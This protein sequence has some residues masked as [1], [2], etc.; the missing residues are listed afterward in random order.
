MRKF[1]QSFTSTHKNGTT[2]TALSL[3]TIMRRIELFISV[4]IPMWLSL[5]EPK[6]NMMGLLLLLMCCL[7]HI[8]LIK[9]ILM[10]MDRPCLLIMCSCPLGIKFNTWRCLNSSTNIMSKIWSYLALISILWSSYILYVFN[11][12]TSTSKWL[13]LKGKTKSS[14]L[15]ENNLAKRSF[16]NIQ[17]EIWSFM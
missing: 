4:S 12:P 10:K 8:N 6:N 7:P 13:M 14:K 2:N 9:L 15:M 1:I 3:Y 5:M 16:L 11:S 17:S